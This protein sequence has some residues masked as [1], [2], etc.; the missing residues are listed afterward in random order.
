MI[1]K[2]FE[3]RIVEIEN[4]GYNIEKEAKVKMHISVL[5]KIKFLEVRKYVKNRERGIM[6]TI[7]SI[8]QYLMV[9]LQK[10]LVLENQR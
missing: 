7:E 4:T 3:S 1:E 5:K 10:F 6:V 9:M 8:R 2:I